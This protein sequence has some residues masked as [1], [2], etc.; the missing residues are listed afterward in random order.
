MSESD[1][2]IPSGNESESRAKE[3]FLNRVQWEELLGPERFSIMRKSGTEPPFRN[4]Y[5]NEHRPG[6]FVCAGSGV[7]LFSS[8]DK[9]DS[10]TGWPSFTRPISD[11]VVAEEVDYSYGMER[12]EVYATACGSHL[13]HVFS[14]GPAPTRER[15]CINSACLDFIPLPEGKS[16]SELHQELLEESRKVIARLRQKGS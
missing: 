8:E 3:V 13:G 1:C 9:F 5:W 4:A 6:I 10:G 16:L 12:R 15:Y 11:D 2:S 14:D 7:P